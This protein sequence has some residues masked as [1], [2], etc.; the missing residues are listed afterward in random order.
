MEKNHVKS[1]DAKYKA[2]VNPDDPL[3]VH[4]YTLDNGLKV[5]I[6]PDH[7]EPRVAM[8]IVVHAGSI[9]E[10]GHATGLAHYLEHMMFKGTDK[11]GTLNWEEESKYLKQLEDLF[12][13]LRTEDD[14]EKQKE[15][16]KK[17]DSISHL[18]SKYAIPNEYEHMYQ[19]I[20]G[21]YLN[22]GT[23]YDFT[24]YY[25]YV[26]S[27]EFRRLL[28]LES[29]RFSKVVPRLFHTEME[30]VFEEF[31]MR[32]QDG[33]QYRAIDKVF[34]M[35]FPNHPM[36]RSVIG[37]PDH[38]KRPSIKE[39][40]KFFNTYYVPNNMTVI[41]TGDV[42]PDEAIR[43]IDSTLG[44]LKPKEVKKPTFELPPLPE[45]IQ[46]SELYGP[47]PAHVLIGYRM[48]PP[49]N[50]KE[51]AQMLLTEYILSNSIAG[52][53]PIELMQKHKVHKVSLGVLD[54]SQGG[55]MIIDAYPREGQTLE[56]VENEVANVMRRF[57]TGELLTDDLVEAARQNILLEHE[58]NWESYMDKIDD[59][60]YPIRLGLSWDDYLKVLDYIKN[61]T[62][63][64]ILAFANKYLTDNYAI[65]YKRQGEPKDRIILEK[66]PIT[67]V[68]LN[69]DAHSEFY[70]QFVAIT[71]PPI[72]PKFVDF[73]KDVHRSRSGPW[74][75]EYIKNEKS[76]IFRLYLKYDFGTHSNPLLE[77]AFKVIPY[78]GADTLSP[79]QFRFELF[80]HGLKLYSNVTPNSA[81]IKLE[82]LEESLPK[83]LAL[84]NSLLTKPV[85]T[86]EVLSNVIK[87]I[88]KERENYRNHDRRLLFAGFQYAWYG[89]NSPYI[90]ILS[91]EELMALSTDDVLNQIRELAY[92]PHKIWY[93]G[94]NSPSQVGSL[95]ANSLPA[96]VKSPE[97]EIKVLRPRQLPDKAAYV[98]LFP[99]VQIT[100]Y[101][102]A[103]N[104]KIN[105]DNYANALLFSS[106][107][108]GSLGSVINQEIRE[109]RGLAYSAGG[110]HIL[111]SYKGDPILYAAFSMVQFDKLA[112]NL[113]VIEELM[114]QFKADP[115]H[116]EVGKQSLK[117]ELETE[118]VTG[119]EIFGY[120]DRSLKRGFDRD[121]REYTYEKLKTLTYDEYKD[122]FMNNIANGNSIYILVMSEEV[123]KNFKLD[124]YK[125][126]QLSPEDIITK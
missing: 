4:H 39:M 25:G 67:P 43:L 81:Y 79:Q 17:I 109:R 73:E 38:L 28:I 2:Y 9:Y 64:D 71:P 58:K 26:P 116:F 15:I 112:E 74:E 115:K 60:E 27:N 41:V 126:V 123:F 35:L 80:K 98:I 99:K 7:S 91:E 114:T 90:N 65:V 37:L 57:R 92:L 94:K 48:P 21:S 44:Q 6:S 86:E 29:E 119:V 107:Y 31:N 30:T 96:S 106:F 13:E 77:V 56:D 95:I 32:F 12:E 102:V 101:R 18:A 22:A 16:Y 11:I 125:I 8:H 52:I 50:L 20:G 19:L 1:V 118:R 68:H 61:M 124:G 5:M 63:E 78:L 42:N 83:G 113:L 14:P 122:Y 70:K 33:E 51:F 75:L 110:F 23:D 66:P 36:S 105:F 45:T 93:Y 49:S 46:R 100:T 111:P 88:I 72:E 89:K 34:S 84:L 104:G 82:G 40:L 10:P 120:I 121:P 76:N 103:E 87:D 24:V 47:K 85:L 117:Q 59:L 53:L 54:Y 97:F 108:G 62:R 55:A 3:R 69:T